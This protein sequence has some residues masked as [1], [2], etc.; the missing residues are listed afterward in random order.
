M[1]SKVGLVKFFKTA[2]CLFLG[3]V[4]LFPAK[5]FCATIVDWQT[6]YKNAVVKLVVTR[7]NYNWLEP[8]KKSETINVCGSGFFIDDAGHFLTNF[9][10]VESAVKIQIQLSAMGQEKLDCAVVGACP[11]LDIALLKI[12][13]VAKDKIKKTTGNLVYFSLGDSDKLGRGV[14][15]TT[16]GFPLNTDVMKVTSGIVSGWETYAMPGRLMPCASVSCFEIT[17][18]INPGSS[19]GP[20]L[21]EKGE[22]IGINFSGIGRAQN[23]GYVLPINELTVAINLLFKNKLLFFPVWG[24]LFHQTN[25][26]FADC[27]RCPCGGCYVGEVWGFL[28]KDLGL[29]AGDMV[30]AINDY[31][32]DCYVNA[33]FPWRDDKVNFATL[34]PRLAPESRLSV[35]FYRNGER[36]QASCSIKYDNKTFKM[37]EF[38]PHY[39]N[40]DYEIFGGLVIMELNVNHYQAFAK[41]GASQSL[42]LM[43]ACLVPD[44]FNK[45]ELVITAVQE[46]S[47]AAEGKAF[48]PPGWLLKKVN[49]NSV[50]TI[51]ELR[52]ELKAGL[53][54]DFLTI[55]ND[56]HMVWVFETAKLIEDEKRLAT[57]FGYDATNSLALAKALKK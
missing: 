41:L 13:D 5:N 26:A 8:Y 43:A 46:T 22:V 39:E 45:S 9:H 24:S 20:A 31:P 37:R 53:A 57:L 49:G 35:T 12:S 19:G 55:T 56:V 51:A 28:A 2:G 1:I 38:F 32:V 54:K 16:L 21:N 36:K 30:C 33:L 34:L 17:A 42:N 11:D 44:N 27:F 3:L 14:A 6:K 47:L 29:C 18:P 4:V 23:V 7:N 50:S 48:F 25:S 52:T 15:V 10:V 40:I